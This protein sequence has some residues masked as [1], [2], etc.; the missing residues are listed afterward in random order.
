MLIVRRRELLDAGVVAGEVRQRLRRGDLVKVRPGAYVSGALPRAPEELHRLRVR[1]AVPAFAPDVVVSHA[2][3]AVVLGLP[4]WG[5]ALDRVHGTRSR[6]TGGRCG[7]TFHLHC[8]SLAP[9]EI[10]EVDGIAVTAPARTVVDV[11]RCVPFEPAVV[12]ADEALREG[13]VSRADLAAALE[14]SAR[15][16]GCPAAR[17]VVDF[18]DGR[19]ESVGESRSR[20]AMAAL[21][22]A[23]PVLQWNVRHP[24]GAWLG[25][26]DFGWPESMTVGEFDGRV[27]YGRLV[28]PGADPGDVVFA[29]K[30]RE[31]ALRDAGLRVVRWTWRDLDPFDGVAKRLRRAF[32]AASPS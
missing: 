23:A 2:S 22:L 13:L 24:S 32:A 16:P 8:A 29:E 18:A 5:I 10:I 26:T 3:A 27:K 17:R 31:D 9:E 30:L 6:R 7:R 15:R 20:V 11:A 28:P 19:S 4:A 25:R 12:L 1:A 14:A 21:G